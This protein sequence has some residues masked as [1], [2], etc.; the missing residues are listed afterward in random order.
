MPSRSLAS[1]PIACTSL[2]KVPMPMDICPP[3]IRLTV[4]ALIPAFSASA[5]CDKHSFI[6]WFR[7]RSPSRR[8]SCDS[9]RLPT[10]V[11]SFPENEHQKTA[12][13]CIRLLSWFKFTLYG[14]R[15]PVPY[16]SWLTS[17]R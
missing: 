2:I 7:M 8:S 15:Y 4:L 12:K 11:S 10:T 1:A 16:R 13:L 9:A 6:L 3:S 17:A 14:K 5:S